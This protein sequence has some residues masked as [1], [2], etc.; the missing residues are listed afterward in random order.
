MS[1]NRPDFRALAA[2]G[3]LSGAARAVMERCGEAGATAHAR[4][5]H[6]R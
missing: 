1:W 5:W 4:R 2:P 6:T 3:R